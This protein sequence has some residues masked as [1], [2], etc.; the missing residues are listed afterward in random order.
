MVV[1]NT[2][3]EQI[4]DENENDNTEESFFLIKVSLSLD[5]ES[6]QTTGRVSLNSIDQIFTMQFAKRNEN[7]T[8]CNRQ[9]KEKKNKKTT[10]VNITAKQTELFH[11]LELINSIK[12]QQSMPKLIALLLMFLFYLIYYGYEKIFELRLFNSGQTPLISDDTFLVHLFDLIL[13]LFL[14][15]SIYFLMRV[16]EVVQFFDKDHGLCNSY[17][18]RDEDSK[19]SSLT[20]TLIR[21]LESHERLS[22]N[23]GTFSILL[24]PNLFNRYAFA[25]YTPIRVIIKVIFLNAG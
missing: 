3:G 5:L 21:L 23:F 24:L 9:N 19:D 18:N 2:Y 6:R 4:N 25:L 20:E 11:Q 16:I 22:A 12:H 7:L 14:T 1:F 15:K 13:F 8:T 10:S 17:N